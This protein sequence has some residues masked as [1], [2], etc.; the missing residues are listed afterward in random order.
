MDFLQRR[1][2][3]YHLPFLL[4]MLTIFVLS[5]IPQDDYPDVGWWGWAK[6]L[7]LLLYGT[8]CILATRSFAHLDSFPLLARYTTL[9]ALVAAILYACTDE[10]HQTF[11][12]GRHGQVSDVLIDTFGAALFLAARWLYMRARKGKERH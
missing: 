5:S 7:H 11:T 1:F 3:R 6:V 12:R 10:Y 4:L 2:V 9:A 8:L